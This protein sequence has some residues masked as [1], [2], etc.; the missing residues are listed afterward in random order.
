LTWK[1]DT[2]LYQERMSQ[3]LIYTEAGKV[4]Q[5]MGIL[6]E[7]H[8]PGAGVG[9][10]CRIIPSEFSD[11][12]QGVDAEVIGFRDKK[13]LLM[14]FEDLP[15]INKDSL[16]VLKKRSSTATVGNVLLGRVLD[17]RGSPI[18][19]KGALVSNGEWIE[20][21]SLYHKPAHPL[22]RDM[23][24]QPLDLGVRAINGLLTCGKGQRLGIMAGSGVGKS[25]LL[26]MMAK[27]TSAD[28]NVI[29]L[30]GERGR[31]VREFIEK[32]LGPEGLKKSV[33]VVSTSDKSPIL[34]MRGAFL[35]TTIAEYFRDQGKDVLLLM[36]SVTRFCMAQREIGLSLGEPPASKGYTPS[37]FS[38]IPKLLERAGMGGKRGSIT[39]LYSVLVEGDEMDDPIADSVRSILDGHVVL[40]RKIAQRNHFPAI[41][42]LQSTSRVMRSV[43]PP[44]QM[45]WAGQIKDWLSAYAQAE[46]LINIGAYVRGSNP[47]VDQSVAV[48]DRIN[49]FLRQGIGESATMSETLAQMHSIVRHGEAFLSAQQQSNQSQKNQL[50]PQRSRF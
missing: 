12:S 31:E 21:R 14:P 25:V 23:I 24:L 30:I 9:S 2:N 5:S 17:G 28:V 19:D 20:E 26:G 43:T 29:A 18:D 49:A 44:E 11:M 39:G 22:E 36:D 35:A 41:D 32:D 40:S 34:R 8:L 50:P 47:R 42:I 13:V 27:H 38:T 3:A 4:S 16:V 15:G 37:V 10:I 7:A 48:I 45:E 33:V 1:I 46:D 6:F